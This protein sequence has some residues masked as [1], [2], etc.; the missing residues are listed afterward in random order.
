M[1]VCDI[2][3]G[4]LS[5]EKEYYVPMYETWVEQNMG[6]TVRTFERLGDCKI[7]LCQACR[8]KLADFLKEMK[9]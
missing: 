4:N 2:C 6:V 9:R 3:K 5:S 1:L 7:N 8:Y